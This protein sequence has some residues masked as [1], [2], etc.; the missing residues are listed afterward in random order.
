VKGVL[1]DDG[2]ERLVGLSVTQVGPFDGMIVS[3][4]DGELGDQDTL[5]GVLQTFDELHLPVLCLESYRP[6]EFD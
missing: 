2:V 1:P 4:L 6:G 3:T 5:L